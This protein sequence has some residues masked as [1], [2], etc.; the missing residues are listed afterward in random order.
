MVE[1][2]GKAWAICWKYYADVKNVGSEINRLMHNIT[3]LQNVFQHVQ[4]LAGGSGAT[5]LVAPRRLLSGSI[6]LELENQV[7]GMLQILQPGRTEGVG[8][9]LG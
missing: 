5:K 1:L 3:A 7:Y 8:R 2:A 4:K 6:S 9:R